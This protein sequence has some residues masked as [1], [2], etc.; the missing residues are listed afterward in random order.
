MNNGRDYDYHVGRAPAE[1]DCSYRATGHA[2][3]AAHMKLSALHMERAR[4]AKAAHAA[5]LAQGG[6]WDHGRPGD[7]AEGA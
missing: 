2:A 7:S 5:R 6:T 4:G 1:M 3:A